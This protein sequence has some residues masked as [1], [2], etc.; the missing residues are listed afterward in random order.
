M[1]VLK[2]IDHVRLSRDARERVLDDLETKCSPR[3]RSRR[4][5][6]RQPYRAVRIPLVVH[7]PGGTQAA[8]LV[9]ARNISAKGIAVI[10][11]S[12]AHEHSIC[13]VLLT[14]SA[15]GLTLIPGKVKHCS[16]VEGRLHEIGIE[17]DEAIDP[18]EFIPTADA[19]LDNLELDLPASAA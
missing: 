13:W 7:Q 5:A 16:H 2:F 12:F 14:G 1:P 18:Q 17:F 6:G 15:G 3:E 4:A 8:C 10:H 19:A 9:F 11:S